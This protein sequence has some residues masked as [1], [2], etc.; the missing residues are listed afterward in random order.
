MMM[1]QENST[2]IDRCEK[3]YREKDWK[4]YPTQKIE[5]FA[6]KEKKNAEMML[7]KNERS[8][9]C[10]ARLQKDREIAHRDSWGCLWL[11]RSSLS[12]AM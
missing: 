9:M 1:M 8:M 6:K 10:S 11:F 3:D 2:K 12:C 7:W 4:S 5:A